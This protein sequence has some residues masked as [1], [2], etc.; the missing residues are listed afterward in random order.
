MTTDNKGTGGSV[1]RGSHGPADD[2]PYLPPSPE[3]TRGLSVTSPKLPEVAEGPLTPPPLTAPTTP[4][5]GG[6]SEGD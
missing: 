2:R 5:A 3:E 6:E 4:P 1:E